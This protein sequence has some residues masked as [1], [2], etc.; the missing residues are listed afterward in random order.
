MKS[1]P[2]QPKRWLRSSRRTL[3][4]GTGLIAV[5]FM[6][7]VGITSYL[8]IQGYRDAYERAEER[9]SSA[10]QLVATNAGWIYETAQQTLRR[11]DEAVGSDLTVVTGNAVI[12]I[13]QMLSALPGQ[14]KVYVV[15]AA[16]NTKFSTDPL[17]KPIDI[18]DREYFTAHEAGAVTHVSGLMVS[19]LEGDQI[20]TISRRL[21]RGAAFTGLPFSRST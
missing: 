17:V 14:A 16:G 21:E 18:R 12:D 20:F 15:D 1:S 11:I 7:F 3:L 9:S 2:I 13:G 6:L 4:A 5:F 10:A 19:R 8:F